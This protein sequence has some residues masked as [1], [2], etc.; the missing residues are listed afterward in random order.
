[1][2][3]S[4]LVPAVHICA[5]DD[6]KPIKDQVLGINGEMKMAYNVFVVAVICSLSHHQQMYIL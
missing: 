1:M 4:V 5:V 2:N 3:V 6:E